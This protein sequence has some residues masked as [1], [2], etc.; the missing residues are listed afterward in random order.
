MQEGDCARARLYDRA[1]RRDPGALRHRSISTDPARPGR[2]KEGFKHFAARQSNLF[3]GASSGSY[4]AL[5]RLTGKSVM[6]L[7]DAQA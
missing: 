4:A 6:V 2:F 5:P 3:G 1:L 7:G